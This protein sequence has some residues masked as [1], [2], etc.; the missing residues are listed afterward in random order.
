MRDFSAAYE[1]T[2]IALAAC[3]GRQSQQLTVNTAVNETGPIHEAWKSEKN[4]EYLYRLMELEH[5]IYVKLSRLRAL[6]CVFDGRGRN[7]IL[8]GHELLP[9]VRLG[10]SASICT[11]QPHVLHGQGRISRMCHTVTHRTLCGRRRRRW[12]DTLATTDHAE[13]EAQPVCVRPTGAE[14]QSGGEG[15]TTR[16]S[17]LG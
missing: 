2:R 15:H 10:R 6:G 9:P 8:R 17:P 1:P 14:P 12:Q 11:A 7:P 4:H 13:V 5:V 16:S 3:A